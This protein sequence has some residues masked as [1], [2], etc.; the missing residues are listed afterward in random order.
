MLPDEKHDSAFCVIIKTSET[1]LSEQR[2]EFIMANRKDQKGR[3]LKTGESQRKDG[4]YQ[5]RYTDIR[6]KRQTV[7]AS[8][9]KILREKEKEIQ[10]ALYSNQNYS[11]GNITV[12]ELVEQYL[13]LKNGIKRKTEIRYQRELG[14]IKKQDFAY[15]PIKSVKPS[16]AKRFMIELSNI[17]SY[18]TVNG[19]KFVLS[20]AFDLAVEESI[21]LKNPFHFKLSSVI[22]NDVVKREALTEEQVETWLSFLKTDAVGA[23]YYDT[24]LL[25]LETGMRIS[26][27]CGLTMEDIDFSK[28]EISIN[29]QLL[30]DSGKS[31]RY[32][33]S[34]KSSA[35]ERIIPLTATARKALKRILKDRPKPKVEWVIDGY[36]NFVFLQK[37]GKPRT[38]DLY[39]RAFQKLVKRY[40]SSHPENPLPEIRPHILRHTFCTRKAE[41]GMNPKAL[42]YLMGHSSI[43]MTLNLYAHTNQGF[44]EEELR[45]IERC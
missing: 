20:A 42:Q 14:R 6:G 30:Y 21:L 1:A 39:D 7:Y 43:D 33:T 35:G 40:H 16:Q 32:I 37:N 22:R 13:A 5:Y 15:L 26:E 24:N 29:H 12:H 17:Y 18:S 45:R 19:I 25:L 34:P 38:G 8:D 3:V 44:A 41:A 10:N 23:R 36:S 27:L 28:N 2:K 11:E 31:E 4:I 9:L